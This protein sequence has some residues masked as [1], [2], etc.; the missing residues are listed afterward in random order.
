V[1]VML[2]FFETVSVLSFEHLKRLKAV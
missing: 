2:E 1:S